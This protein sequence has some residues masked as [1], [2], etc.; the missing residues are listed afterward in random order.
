M[1]LS[2]H[3]FELLEWLKSTDELKHIPVVMISSRATEKYVNKATSLGCSGFLGKPYLLENLVQMF[4]KYLT[5]ESPITL[6]D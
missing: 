6:D 5:L 4:N 3:G 1:R 2:S